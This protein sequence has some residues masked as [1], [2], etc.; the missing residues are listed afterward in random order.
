[1][2]FVSMVGSGFSETIVHSGSDL[3]FWIPDGL[4]REQDGDLLIISDK[5]GEATMTVCVSD[6]ATVEDFADGMLSEI[7]K[8]IEDPESK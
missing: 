3:E 4:D 8:F 1:L 5:D 2:I 7:G 6:T